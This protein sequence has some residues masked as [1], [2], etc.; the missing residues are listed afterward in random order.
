VDTLPPNAVDLAA[1]HSAEA[2][3][4]FDEAIT[5]IHTTQAALTAEGLIHADLHQ[6]NFLFHHGE[7][8]AIDFD[9]CGYG[10]HLYDLATTISELDNPTLR[11][12]LLAGYRTVNPLD[13]EEA[14]DDLILLRRLQLTTWV[15]NERHDPQFRA[16]WAT[17]LARTVDHLRE[18]S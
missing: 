7:V 18:A 16:T 17:T 2:A 8:R 4:L 5:R 6:E 14:L 9:D 1:L 10:S 3:R 13:H 12:P 15:I 11:A